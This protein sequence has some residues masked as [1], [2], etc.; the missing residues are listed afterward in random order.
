MNPPTVQVPQHQQ[1]FR[2]P[3]L[4]TRK[5]AKIG[6]LLLIL[7]FLFLSGV[8]LNHYLKIDFGILTS[9]YVWIGDMDKAY[10]D[11]SWINWVIRLL[12]VCGPLI[13]ILVNLLSI[14]HIRYEKSHNEVI[15]SV[16]LRWSNLVIIVVCSL[17][18]VTFFT[19]LLLE[20]V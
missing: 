16:K 11:N 7:P 8:V 5:S 10:G 17:I 3:L 4:N 2:V 13:A 20:N 19:Y 6:V 15:F 1:E 9:I 14:V 18:F 12:L